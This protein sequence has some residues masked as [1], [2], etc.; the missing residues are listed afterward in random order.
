M[1]LK[2]GRSSLL[3]VFATNSWD[4]VHV[5]SGI[6]AVSLAGNTECKLLRTHVS[7]SERTLDLIFVRRLFERW[8]PCLAK[9]AATL[10]SPHSLLV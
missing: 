6:F 7:F 2:H 8:E 1:I 9:D 5:S 3:S 4:L 10:C